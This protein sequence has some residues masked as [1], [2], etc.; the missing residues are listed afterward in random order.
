MLS[1]NLDDKL[2][3]NITNKYLIGSFWANEKG[4][5]TLKSTMFSNKVSIQDDQVYN[6]YK[7]HYWRPFL[8]R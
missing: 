2:T 8:G 3:L 6:T 4:F 1:A 7:E 5:D